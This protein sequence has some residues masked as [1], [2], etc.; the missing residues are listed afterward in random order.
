MQISPRISSQASRSQDLPADAD[1]SWRGRTMMACAVV[2]LMLLVVAAFNLDWS[3]GP[4]MAFG[5]LAGIAA[6]MLVL[7]ILVWAMASMA[8]RQR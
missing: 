8:G 4:A 2:G 5:Q 6:P 1:L 3:E 7:G